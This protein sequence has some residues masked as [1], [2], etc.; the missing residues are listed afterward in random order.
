MRAVIGCETMRRRCQL[1][2]RKST[3]T[4]N[5]R[6][7]RCGF[8]EGVLWVQ[9]S[10][11]FKI[12]GECIRNHRIKIVPGALLEVS[13][14]SVVPVVAD[15]NIVFRYRRELRERQKRLL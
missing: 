12:L 15:R 4:R 9:K 3:C 10:D 7:R 14:E 6:L 8:D 2:V 11:C 1:P 5:A 13:L